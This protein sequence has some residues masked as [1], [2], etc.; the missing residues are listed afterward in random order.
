MA[1][2][3]RIG[4][5]RGMGC[6]DHDFYQPLRRIADLPVENTLASIET[7]FAAGADYVEVDAVMSGDGVLFTL[8]NV[9]PKDH[10]FDR[11]APG[12]LLNTLPFDQIAGFGTGRPFTGR[13]DKLQDVLARIAQVSPRALPWDVNVEIKGVQGSGQ[14]YETNDYLQRLADT[15]LHSGLAAERVLFSSFSLQNIMSMSRLLPAAQYGML[16]AEK[17]EPRAIYADRGDD[18][19][20][21]Y[22]PFNPDFIGSVFAR[23][24][25]DA[26]PD[27]ALKYLHPEAMTITPATLDACRDRA[28][29][30]N[31]W[32]IF[33]ELTPARGQYYLDLAARCAAQ[34]VALTVITDYIP[35]MKKLFEGKAA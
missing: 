8:H 25:Q 2:K 32:A 33:E 22:V 20:F 30:I 6:T 14:P 9:V 19:A 31:C 34:G 3:I 28:A 21:Q 12:A 15:V 13:I 26:A 10:F 18:L 7:A 1:Q 16:F 11:V 5:H 35:E 4:G 24:G 17:P 29:G 27:A 23:W